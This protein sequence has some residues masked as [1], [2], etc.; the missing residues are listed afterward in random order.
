MSIIKTLAFVILCGLSFQ[1]SGAT[2]PFRLGQILTAEI[3]RNTVTVNNLKTI[4]YDFNF[5]HYAY[6]VVVFK[7]NKGRSISIYDFILNLNDKEYKCVAMRAG[8]KNF[9]TRNWKS[10]RTSPKTLY[11][12]LFIV[13]SNVLG[14]AKK[15]IP[16]NLIYTLNKSGQTSYELPFK[17]INYVALTKINNIPPS[18]IFPR[19]KI[20]NIKTPL[21]KAKK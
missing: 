21:G 2:I 12:L 4:D 15:T 17:F 9:D 16:A 1:L 8:S 19:V 7:L 5:K 14:N 11:S 13:D 6:A 18:G 20:K 3:S 10:A